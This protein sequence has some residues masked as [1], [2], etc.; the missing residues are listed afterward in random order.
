MLN[1]HTTCI[2]LA[3]KGILILG[4]PGSGKSDLALRLIR[5]Y[6]AN[7]VSDDRTDIEIENNKVIAHTPPKI[8]GLLEVRGVGIQ[9]IP[10][11]KTTEINLAVEL[12]KDYRDV[13][14]LPDDIFYEIGGI[15]IPCIKLYPFEVTATDKIVIKLESVVE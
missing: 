10:Y 3:G 7:L 11:T 8:A 5:H 15:K 1:I 13:D 4:A 12:V 9:T 2:S 14:R 6:G